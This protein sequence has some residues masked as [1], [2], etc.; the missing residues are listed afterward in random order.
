MEPPTIASLPDQMRLPGNN[1][2][3]RMTKSRDRRFP[4]ICFNLNEQQ[5]CVLASM[6]LR[7]PIRKQVSFL[8]VRRKSTDGGFSKAISTRDTF[9]PLRPAQATLSSCS[10]RQGRVLNSTRSWNERTDI[11]LHYLRTLAA[12]IIGPHGGPE[13][14]FEITHDPRS[15]RD[16]EIHKGNYY[17]DEDPGRKSY[18]I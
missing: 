12:G 17:V 6:D 14:G 5:G 11:L 18:S 8:P 16:F 7:L 9:N 1:P 15:E 4:A 3:C 2:W 10:S 13:D